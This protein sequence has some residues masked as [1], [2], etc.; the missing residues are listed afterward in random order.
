M[1]LHLHKDDHKMKQMKLETD[2]QIKKSLHRMSLRILDEHLKQYD[3]SCFEKMNQSIYKAKETAKDNLMNQFRAND[4][5]DLDYIEMRERQ[6]VLLQ[7][8]YKRVTIIHTRPVTAKKISDFLE[9]MSRNYGQDNTGKL[10]WKQFQEL[11]QEL[12]KSPLPVKREEFETRA[13]L[14]VLLRNIEE[15]L[16]I[17]IDFAKENGH[18]RTDK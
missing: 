12:K 18:E 5:W 11:D 7:E 6:V 2:E 15:F 16:K 1:N 17:K 3:G 13:T 9:N 8:M 10:L 4:Y 14:Y